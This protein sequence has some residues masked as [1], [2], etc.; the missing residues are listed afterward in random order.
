MGL[1]VICGGRSSQ[2]VLC[3]GQRD[4][5]E[6]TYQTHINQVHNKTN[7]VLMKDWLFDLFHTITLAINMLSTCLYVDTVLLVVVE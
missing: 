6:L 5:G 4:P 2:T 1:L 3:Q 7:P